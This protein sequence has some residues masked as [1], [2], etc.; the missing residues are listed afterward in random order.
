MSLQSEPVEHKG[1]RDPRWSLRTSGATEEECEHLVRYPYRLGSWGGERV[2]LNAMAADQLAE[3]LEVKLVA[4]GVEKLVPDPDVLADGY[5]RAVRQEAVRRAI[6]AALAGANGH[7]M[8]VP[9]DL[10]ADVTA[11]ITDA[12]DSWDD[13]LLDIVRGRSGKPGE[14]GAS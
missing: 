1:H 13:A 10:V 12:A 3:W 11:R 14:P 4:A 2:E 9:D 7:H 8:K 6:E 5:R